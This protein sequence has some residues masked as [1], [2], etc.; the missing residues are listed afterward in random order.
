LLDELL[1]NKRYSLLFE[2]GHRW[3]DLRR[4]G[5]LGEL[6]RDLPTHTVFDRYPFPIAECDARVPTPSQGCSP[7]SGTP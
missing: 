3:I 6:P 1:Y 7:V 2:G 4:Y 5:K